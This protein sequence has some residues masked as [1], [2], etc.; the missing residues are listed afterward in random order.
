MGRI[1]WPVALATAFVLLVGWYV[2]YT[3]QIVRA[4]QANAETLAEIYGEVQEGLTSPPGGEVQALSRLQEVILESGVPM[5]LTGPRDTVLAVENLPFDVDLDTAEGQDRVRA[6]VRRLDVRHPPVGDPNLAHM[7]YGD[8][9]EVLRLRWIPWL[10]V[11]GLLLTVVVGFTMI[12]YQRRV[13]GER[14]WTSMAREPPRTRSTNPTA[15][16]MTS[17]I[18]TCFKPAE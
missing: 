17:R 14:A 9:P 1:K 5:V 2:I 16:T 8:T 7:H 6:Y 13:E 10:Q 11:A 3:Q 4:L 18:T 15:T 12:R